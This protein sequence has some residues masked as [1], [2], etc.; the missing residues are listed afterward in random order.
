MS[1]HTT[2]LI[3]HDPHHVPD[4]ACQQQA[5][6]YFWQLAPRAADVRAIIHPHVEL[7]HCGENF[8]QIRCPL[9]RVTITVA[10]WSAAM[11]RDY[12]DMGA[13]LAPQ[14]F[15]CCDTEH[16]LDELLYDPAIGYARF[17]LQA[18]D[19]NLGDLR[20]ADVARFEALLRTP[21]RVIH[22]HW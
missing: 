8:D 14:S 19:A 22:A 16:R 3:P 17:G 11:S 7:F 12:G 20:P 4:V 2:T 15:A 21:L 5:V 13:A 1:M 10:S 18:T 9:T 6:D